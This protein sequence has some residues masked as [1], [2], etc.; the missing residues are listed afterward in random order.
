MI[1]YGW[2]K[3]TGGQ[4]GIHDP[5]LL[6][7]PI[8]EVDKFY[9]AWYL[10]SLSKSFDIGVGLLQIIGA[11]LIVINRTMLIGALFLLPI[12]FQIFLVDVAFTNGFV[13]P[14]RLGCMLVSDFIILFYYKDKMLAALKVLTTNVTTHFKYKWWI[15]LLMPIVGLLMDIVWAVITFPLHHLLHWITKSW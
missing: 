15:Y 10:F 2:A 11:L 7:K 4:F 6:E 9:L 14:I 8:K 1:D 3:M 5:K 12:L 13:L